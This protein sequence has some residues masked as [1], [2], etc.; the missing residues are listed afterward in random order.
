GD[1]DRA[2]INANQAGDGVRGVTITYANAAS[3]DVNVAGLGTATFIDINTVETFRYS[4]DIAAGVGNDVV[5][6][7]GTAAIGAKFPREQR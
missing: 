4:G 1:R 7:V 3:G 6:V 5:T 2:I